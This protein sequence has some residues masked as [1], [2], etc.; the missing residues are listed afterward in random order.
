MSSTISPPIEYLKSALSVNTAL[1]CS[2]G[3]NYCVVGEIARKSPKRISTPEDVVSD[4]VDNRL[5]IPDITPLAIN[6][7]TDP[8]L[9][10]V[11]EDTFRI[12]ELL[13]ERDFQNPRIVISKLALTKRD[14]RDFEQL[15]TPLYFITSYSHLKFPIEKSNSENQLTSFRTLKDK[16]KVVSL[17]Y[18]RPIVR[19]LND[20][21]DSIKRVLE[22]VVGSCDGSILSGLRITQRIKEGME[23]YGA[24]L[25][26]WD[27][28][29]NHKYLPV[30]IQEKIFSIRDRLFPEY[31][32][33]RHTSCGL[34]STVESADYGLNFLRGEPHCV[35]SCKNRCVLRIKPDG[36][37]VDRSLAKIGLNREYSVSDREVYIR[38]DLSQEEKSFLSYNLK[39]PIKADRINKTISERLITEE[40]GIR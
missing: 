25:S 23:S 2:L 34:S 4:L 37:E 12:L 8:F 30:E 35:P 26:G 31:P 17:H 27:G 13:Q 18:W 14:L 1:G 15:N 38:G 24:D 29:T 10:F 5:F 32:L 11:K 3:C 9:G 40:D 6:N 7:K 39:F 36:K 28:D 16:E 21:E 19:N 22:N 20:G 33:Y